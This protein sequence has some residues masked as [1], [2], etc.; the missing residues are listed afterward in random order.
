MIMLEIAA[1]LVLAT[2]LLVLFMVGAGTG[3]VR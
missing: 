3:N 1:V 2:V